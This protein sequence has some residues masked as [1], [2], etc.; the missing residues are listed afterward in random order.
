MIEL[1]TRLYKFEDHFKPWLSFNFELNLKTGLIID[2]IRDVNKMFRKIC[3][4]LSIIVLLNYLALAKNT[5]CPRMK[6]KRQWGGQ[7]SKI[8]DYRPIP[9][10][11]VIIHHTV[12]PE[13]TTFLKCS[14]ILQ[15]MQY[16]H[17]NELEFNDIGY[18]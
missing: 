15:N 11:Y 10:K 9:I 5:D 13:C 16:Y 1:A 8:I 3:F 7:L 2:K 14:E 18:K 6:L 4:I 12:T 17:T